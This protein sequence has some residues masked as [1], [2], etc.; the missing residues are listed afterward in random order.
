[1]FAHHP[2]WSIADEGARND[3]IDILTRHPGVVGYFTGH[4]HKAE[5]RLVHPPAAREHDARYHH[6]WEVT[7]A[8][9][10]EYPQQAA[11]VTLKVLGDVGYLE[12]LAFSPTGTGESEAKIE[13]AR[14]GARRDHCRQSAAS[15][16]D[17]IPKLPSRTATFPRLF[18]RLPPKR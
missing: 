5:L 17:G 15:C 16:V 9:V 6:F 13:R 7:A 10:I 3:V 8:S 2:L 14:A 11:Q 12:V 4:T 18:F 1:V